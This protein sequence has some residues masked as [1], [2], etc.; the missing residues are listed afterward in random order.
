MITYQEIKPNP[1]LAQDI[2]S[3]W[4]STNPSQ[5]S[6]LKS[7]VPDGCT[8]I[9]LT[10]SSIG[11]EP[12]ISVVGQMTKYLEVTLC[13]NELYIGI[14]FNPGLLYPFLNA[15]FHEL[16]DNIVEL[17]LIKASLAHRLKQAGQANYKIREIEKQLLCAKQETK[18]VNTVIHYAC[19]QILATGGAILVRNLATELG[20]SERYLQKE[21]K[22]I[23]GVSPKTL[24]RIVRFNQLKKNMKKTNSKETLN[25]A[26]GLGY[27]DQAHFINEFKAFTGQTPSRSLFS[28]TTL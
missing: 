20:I 3:Y 19:Q 24:S 25:L 9:I 11:D 2:A 27:Y 15:P 28:N 22:K 18:S 5:Q 8:D 1:R 21:F 12:K 13:P 26:L 6:T 16:T 7:I 17:S 10:Y 14:R 4:I 23:V